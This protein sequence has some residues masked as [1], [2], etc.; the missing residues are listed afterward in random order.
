MKVERDVFL[1]DLKHAT[2]KGNEFREC[3]TDF[4]EKYDG[5]AT[6]LKKIEADEEVVEAH[7]ELVEILDFFG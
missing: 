4:F 1:K 6:E 3:L 5:H 2:L 7:K